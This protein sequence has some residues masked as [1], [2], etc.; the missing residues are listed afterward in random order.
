[1]RNGTGV[2][3]IGVFAVAALALALSP[4]VANAADYVLTGSKWGAKQTAAVAAAGGTVSFSHGKSG[5]GVAVS[6]N[7]Q[8]LEQAMASGAFQKG[9]LDVAVQWQM[10]TVV[11]QAVNPGN[12]TF[13]PIQWNL[14]A[15]E[16]PAAWAAG[17]TGEGVRV[18][19]LDGGIYDAHP[20]LAANMDVAC[21][22]SFTGNPFNTDLGTFWHGTHVAGIIG[23]VDNNTGVVGVAPDVTLVGV[24]VLHG[25]TGSFGGV[26]GGILYAADPASF[27]ASDCAKA[28]IINM[29]LGAVFAKSEPGGGPLVAA[30]N[31]AL[32]FAASNGV[33][34]VSAAGND[35]VDFGQA[36]NYTSVPAESG[37]GIAVSAT[38]PMGW[39][40]GATDYDRPAS[41]SNYG[42]GMIHVAAPGGDSAYPGEEICSV[43]VS[44]GTVTV[45][46][47]VFDLVI[48][49]SRGA[50][51]AG[52]Y[53]WAGGTSMAAPAAAGVA[54][55]IKGANPGI[56]LGALKSRL[57]QTATDS[58][59]TGNDE[60]YGR[61][62]VNANNAC[63]Y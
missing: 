38:A 28:D 58:G 46:C 32:N 17:C 40:L 41:Y 10:P 14:Q 54:A 22:T 19:V 3:R 33:L 9:S 52:A 45:P 6:D 8:F 16:A 30:M 7:P 34:V 62:F 31:K 49:T 23:A 57:A 43:P 47:W 21:S 59:K 56:S 5:I 44:G 51:A 1:M 36:W 15:I 27:G 37:S 50:T 25:G 60:F 48:S 11:E 2:P 35:G 53:S 55:L 18:A 13:Y 20:D 26:I 4:V 42:E 63:S 29:S 24:K 39:A 61:G 12:D